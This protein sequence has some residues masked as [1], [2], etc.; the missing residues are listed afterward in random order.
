[1]KPSPSTPTPA[2]LSPMFDRAAGRYDLLN[3]LMSLG[4]DAS[5]RRRLAG[6]LA[7]G[8]RVLDVCCGSGRSALA[9]FRRC[10]GTVVGV[11]LSPR[12][13]ARGRAHAARHGAR[14]APVRGDAFRLP[15]RDASFDAVTLAWGLRNLVPEEEALAELRRVLA[16]GGRL[17]VLDS[18]APA[19]GVVGAAHEFYLRHVVPL[20]GRLSSDPDAYRY[21]AD[22]VLRFGTA[23]EVAARLS[24]AG[25]TCLPPESLLLG[26]AA[27]WRA[28]CVVSAA[29][30]L[31]I[32]RPDS[33]PVQQAGAGGRAWR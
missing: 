24:R 2:D 21:L 22:S 16:P 5:W 27:V 9:A 12:M 6:P 26:A 17:H 23:A 13:L 3:S 33:G 7:A 31:Q 14:F 18:P 15:F 20:L 25:F 19:A 28:R 4:R 11:D 29:G 10:G 32:A 8:E 1:M 30:P